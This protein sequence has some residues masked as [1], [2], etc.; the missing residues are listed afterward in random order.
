MQYDWHPWMI[1]PDF[2]VRLFP[3]DV[4]NFHCPGCHCGEHFLSIGHDPKNPSQG[5]SIGQTVVDG[6]PRLHTFFY[7]GPRPSRKVKA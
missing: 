5:V 2:W 3:P 6:D 7:C 1:E 4:E